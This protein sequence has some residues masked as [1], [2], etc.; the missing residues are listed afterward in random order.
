MRTMARHYNPRLLL[1]LLRAADGRLQRQRGF[2]LAMVLVVLLVAVVGAGSLALRSV[3][4]QAGTQQLSASREA[5]EAAESGIVAIISE[6]NRPRNRRLLVSGSSP[7]LWGSAT[8]LRQRNPCLQLNGVV[9]PSLP[10]NTLTAANSQYVLRSVRYADATRA[11]RLRFNFNPVSPG[12]P[13]ENTGYDNNQ[14]GAIN[15]DVNLDMPGNGLQGN[16]GYLQLEVEGRAIRNGATIATATVL[17]EYEV[18]PK[19]CERSFSGPVRN[20]GNLTNTFGNDGQTCGGVSADLGLIYGFGGGTLTVNGSAGS[21]KMADASGNISNQNLDSVLCVTSDTTTASSN[22]STQSINFS[23]GSVP[24][25]PIRINVDP[26]PTFDGSSNT[27]VLRIT[28]NYA[29][30]RNYFR[31]SSNGQRI[32]ECL[33]SE[34]RNPSTGLMEWRIQ[35]NCQAVS[36]CDKVQQ[37]RVADFHCRMRSI[38]LTSNTAFFFDTSRGTIALFFDEPK[39]PGSVN[40]DI[41]RV[42]QAGTS[43]IK[44]VYCPGASN[45]GVGAL[46]C[47]TNASTN[48]FSRLAFYGSQSYNVFE[49]T[50]TSDVVSFFVY[51][52]NGSI[53]IGGNATVVGALWTNNLNI[54]GSFVAAAPATSC[55]TTASTGFCYIAQGGTGVSTSPFLFDWVARTPV[56]TRVY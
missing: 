6:L 29:A 51:F 3:S 28:N 24:V 18:I 11:R 33:V 5:R 34:V 39:P 21:L 41:G 55:A 53:D 4:G 9:T 31:V 45:G 48:E 10:A 44:H 30:S 50:G 17:K 38:E 35:S 36:G 25:Q 37:S 15:R 42:Y 56:T 19:C 8:D 1:L 23:S 49:Y 32:E 2:S 46:A 13:A 22:C 14:A 27:P 52:S 7:E 47:T 54:Q 43:A 16:F 26:P 12:A 20:N 40:S